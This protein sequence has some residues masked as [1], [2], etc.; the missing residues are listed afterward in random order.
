VLD[1]EDKKIS[2]EGCKDLGWCLFE[3]VHRSKQKWRCTLKMGVVRI[4]GRDYYFSRANVEME[5]Q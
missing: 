3:K 5:F 2:D 1:A 4:A